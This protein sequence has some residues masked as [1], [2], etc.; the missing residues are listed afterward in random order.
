MIM[1]ET[2]LLHYYFNL[3]D[4]IAVSSYV[5]SLVPMLSEIIPFKKGN[6]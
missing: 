6:L 3:S 2:F 4:Y 5:S 1:G